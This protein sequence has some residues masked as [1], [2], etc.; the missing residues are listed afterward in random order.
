MIHYIKSFSL[1]FL[2]LFSLT[3]QTGSWIKTK[4][5]P[6]TYKHIKTKAILTY[7]WIYNRKVLFQQSLNRFL[8]HHEKRDLILDDQPNKKYEHIK[9]KKTLYYL[10]HKGL[11]HIPFL[12]RYST[13]HMDVLG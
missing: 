9:I 4:K 6:H 11:F 13:H 5:I 2:L 3:K 1:Y 10:I 8:T 12:N 7:H